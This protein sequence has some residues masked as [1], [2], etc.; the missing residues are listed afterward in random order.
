MGNQVVV[1][2]TI[3]PIVDE[4]TGKPTKIAGFE[5]EINYKE[6]ELTFI[7]AQTGTLPGSWM[8]YLNESEPDEEGYV[9]ISFGSI[10]KFTKQCTTRLLHHRRNGWIR[11][12]IPSQM[13]VRII[14]RV[15]YSTITI[16][17]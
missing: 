7:D 13:L 4:F 11:I 6:S 16:C 8:T 9:T 12:N 3:T 14:T 2:L 15:D 1:P 17:W 5:F 10:R